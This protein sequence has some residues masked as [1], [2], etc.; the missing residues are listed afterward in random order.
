MG[1]PRW[2]ALAFKQGDTAAWRRLE[3]CVLAAIEGYHFTLD[4]SRLDALVQRLESIPAE[5]RGFAYEG[6]ALGLAGLDLMLPSGSRFRA[7]V[8]GPGAAHVYMVHI[9]FGEALGLLHRRPEPPLRRL[10]PILRWLAVDG[11]GF[12][13]GFFSPRRY[14][15]RQAVPGHL[16]PYGRCVFDQGLGRAAWFLQGAS[17][18]RVVATVAGFPPGRRADL[19]AGVGV[20]CAYAG[21]AERADVE[22][23]REAAGDYLPWLAMGAAVVAKGRERAGNPAAH[24]DMACEVLCGLSSTAA[25]RVTDASFEDLPVRGPEEAYS[26]LQRRLV[27]ALP[28][29]APR[30]SDAKELARWRR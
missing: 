29:R 25:A 3:D 23:L 22:A 18:R 7:F 21:G 4:D 1:V 6:A 30:R 11:Y 24:G 2:R 9:G 16:S 19:W 20:A 10:D 14:L 28:G 8:D 26:V 15:E 27:A 12:H 5:L 17:V 13:K